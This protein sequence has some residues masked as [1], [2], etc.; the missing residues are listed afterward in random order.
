MFVGM[1]VCVIFALL[2]KWLIVHKRRGADAFTSQK[3]VKLQVK[4][5]H[6]HFQA[7][8]TS[9]IKNIYGH[10]FEEELQKSKQPVTLT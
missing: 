2:S 10:N 9:T 1:R 8:S 6:A 5:L 4:I 3:W 7:L